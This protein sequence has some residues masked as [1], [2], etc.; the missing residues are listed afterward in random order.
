MMN[1][2]HFPF[3]SLLGAVIFTL[4]NNNLEDHFG[5]HY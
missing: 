4:I 5:S 3:L 2:L 1:N